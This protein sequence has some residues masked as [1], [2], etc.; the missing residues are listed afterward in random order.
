MINPARLQQARELRG[1]TQTTL[2][3]QVGVHQS[4]I[5]QLEAGRIQPS[6]EVLAAISR[7]TGFPP[8]FFTRPSTP[9]FP[10]GSLR[11]RAR[12]AMTAR[13][14]R[15]AS[16]YAHTLYELMVS[17]AT[18]TEYPAPR[19]PRMTGDPVAAARHTREAL[20]LASDRPIGSLIRA[21]ERSGVWVVAIPVPLPRRDAFSAWAGGDAS[22]PVIV[23]AAT[24]AGDRRRF[25]VAHELGHLVLHQIP[26]G[27][28]HGLERQADMFAEA[29]LLPEAAMRRVL[30]PPITLTTLADLKA[31][32]GVSL[33][34]LIQ[35]ARTLEMITRSHYRALYAQLGARGWRTQEPIAVPVE[36]PRALRQL[37]ELLYGR[38]IRY[39][40]L[41]DA[42]GLPP[43][44][45]QDLLEA[46]AAGGEGPRTATPDH[47][48]R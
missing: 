18:Q 33:Q 15:Q 6:P 22:T 1:E 3:R 7:H 31:R 25:S 5:A 40:Q 35:R 38:P 36:R 10:L 17:M 30:V 47:A 19:V 48:R 13:Q 21:L 39:A 11:F 8:A 34:A 14:R 9:A 27:S 12:A 23:V 20:D 42:T 44:F 2:A 41:A 16:W 29:F 37:A 24:T 32:W 28:P 45:V 26:Q 4:A 43:A 46:H